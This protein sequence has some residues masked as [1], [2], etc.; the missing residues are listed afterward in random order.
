MGSFYLV[1]LF[2]SF[3]V[4]IL[5]CISIHGTFMQEVYLNKHL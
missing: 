4:D 3:F 1:P 2:H 5:T